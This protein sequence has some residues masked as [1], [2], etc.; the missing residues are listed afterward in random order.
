MV[1]GDTLWGWQSQEADGRWSLIAMFA[2]TDAELASSGSAA[3]ILARAGEMQ[4]LVH[5]RRSVVEGQRKHALAHFRRFGQPIRL[6]RFNLAGVA[7][8][9]E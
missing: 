7:E 6:A 5:R 3:E 2:T 4:V 9:I 8:T 1:E